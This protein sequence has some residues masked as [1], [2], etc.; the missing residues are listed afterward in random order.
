MY[1][2]FWYGE[3][4]RA[5]VAEAIATGTAF[6]G[7]VLATWTMWIRRRARPVVE[8]HPIAGERRAPV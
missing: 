4:T 8:S 3:K 6:L 2:P 1:E 7:L 5:A